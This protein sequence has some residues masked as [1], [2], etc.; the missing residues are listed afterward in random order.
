MARAVLR[1]RVD[2]LSKK[3]GVSWARIQQIERT[4]EITTGIEEKL[5]LL[6]K[7]FISNGIVFLDS[8]D[9]KFETIAMK[10]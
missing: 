2:D 1:W 4:D 7:T 10:K 6:K 3:S 9:D 8:S 5:E